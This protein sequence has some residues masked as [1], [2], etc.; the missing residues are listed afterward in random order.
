[1]CDMFKLLDELSLSFQKRTITMFKLADTVVAFKAKVELQG[2]QV[3]IGIFDMFP[4]LADIL[5]E[6]EPEPY[7]SQLVYDHLSK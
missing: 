3:N 4:I 5:K 6:T 2:Q 1:M 7:F